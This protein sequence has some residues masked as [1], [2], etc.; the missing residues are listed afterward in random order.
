MNQTPSNNK[1]NESSVI[2]TDIDRLLNLLEEGK[3]ISVLDLAKK[4]KVKIEQVEKWAKIL[5]EHGLIEIEYPIIG[6]PRL[7]KK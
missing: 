6:L 4:L 7:K 3:S 5:E 2:Q 1:S